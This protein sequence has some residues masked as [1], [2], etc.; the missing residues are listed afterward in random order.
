MVHLSL[1]FGPLLL[2]S[3]SLEMRGTGK[4]LWIAGVVSHGH[5]KGEGDPI[6]GPERH[7][8]GESSGGQQTLCKSV[9]SGD[10]WGISLIQQ[11]NLVRCGVQIYLSDD[12]FPQTYLLPFCSV[13]QCTLPCCS[14]ST[15]IHDHSWW[16]ALTHTYHTK[17]C[18][19]QLIT[20]RIVR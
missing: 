15:D 4:S 9:Y 3:N 18:N 14:C 8:D 10:F 17:S 13:D 6:Q 11:L 1:Q 20:L 16:V 7:R 12:T 2:T 5:G 19:F